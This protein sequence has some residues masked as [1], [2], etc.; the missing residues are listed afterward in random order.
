M[1]AGRFYAL[2]RFEE[3]SDALRA[4]MRLGLVDQMADRWWPAEQLRQT[5]GF[6]QQAARTFFALLQVMEIVQHAGGKYRVTPAAAACL[7]DGV[8]SSRIHYFSNW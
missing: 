3:A 7:A 8:A 1:D 2:L 5:L 6:T 4:V